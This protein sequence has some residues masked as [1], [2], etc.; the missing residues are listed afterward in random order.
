MAS[1]ARTKSSGKSRSKVAKKPACAPQFAGKRVEV[2]ATKFGH[3]ITLKGYIGDAPVAEMEL[4]CATDRCEVRWARVGHVPAAGSM[5]RDVRAEDLLGCG[6]GTQMYEAAWEVACGMRK[7]LASDRARSDAAEGFWAKQKRKG[8]ARCVT[9]AR[10]GDRFDYELWL[11]LHEFE[12]VI[13]E[14]VDSGSISYAEGERQMRQYRARMKGE[15]KRDCAYY[16]V[17]NACPARPEGGGSPYNFKGLRG[18]GRIPI[19]EV[20]RR[21]RRLLTA[22]NSV[23]LEGGPRGKRRYK[24]R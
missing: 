11:G 15:G 18:L 24:R 5:S 2:A 17:T 16:E 10:G 1:T 8:R 7:R 20:T 9:D 21:P 19:R 14:R 13:D 3:E 12:Q 4:N 23:T 6:I 22:R